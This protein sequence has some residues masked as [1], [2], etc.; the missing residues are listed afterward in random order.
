MLCAVVGVGLVISAPG[1]AEAL[2]LGPTAPPAV[3]NAGSGGSAQT[4]FNVTAPLGVQLTAPVDGV[5][6]RFRTAANKPVTLR[7]VRKVGADYTG[8]GTGPQVPGLATGTVVTTETRLPIAAGDTIGLDVPPSTAFGGSASGWTF[9]Y[10]LPPV[11]DGGAPQAVNNFPG[12]LAYV[13][14]DF[15][16]DADGD[17]F[18]DESQDRCLGTSGSDQGCPPAVPS[19][20]PTGQRAAALKKCKKKHTAKARKRC[21]KKANLLPV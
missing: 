20:Q 4:L 5:I 3:L 6:T 16:L 18:G 9:A 14:A 1:D 10:T 11:P 8:A 15:E 13:N 21:R 19:S 7:I 2:T 17:L 12:V